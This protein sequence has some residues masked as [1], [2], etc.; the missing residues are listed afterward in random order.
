M[1]EHR[2]ELSWIKPDLVGSETEFATEL[3]LISDLILS[4]M[5]DHPTYISRPAA[6]RWNPPRMPEHGTNQTS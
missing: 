6:V 5:T 2:S 3:L 4:P 1:D